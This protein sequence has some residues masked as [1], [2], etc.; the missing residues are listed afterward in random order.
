MLAQSQ[1]LDS[2]RVCC[3]TGNMVSAQSLYRDNST[4]Y[5]DARGIDDGIAGRGTR[6]ID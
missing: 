4:T 2:N 6:L 3:V 5:K 1:S